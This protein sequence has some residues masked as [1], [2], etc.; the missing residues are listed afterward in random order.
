M[1]VSRS[2]PKFQVSEILCQG[3]GQC[4]TKMSTGTRQKQLGSGA[5]TMALHWGGPGEHV[6][7]WSLWWDPQRSQSPVALSPVLS[8]VCLLE[9]R[10]S[11]PAGSEQPVA[12]KEKGLNQ[13]ILDALESSGGCVAD[14]TGAERRKKK[15][16]RRK[17]KEERRKKKEERRKKKEERRKKKEERRKKKEERRKKKEERRKK[18]EERRKKKEEGPLRRGWRKFVPLPSMV[19]HRS[20]QSIEP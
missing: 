5:S 4:P 10:S 6:L 14:F 15:E 18:K 16:E 9:P 8:R 20:S 12:Q 11:E 17:K 2:S 7:V 13:T 19:A 1:S 3:D